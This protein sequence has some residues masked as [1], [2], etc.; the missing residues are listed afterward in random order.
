MDDK[1]DS[2]HVQVIKYV[3]QLVLR[4]NGGVYSLVSTGG[5]IGEAYSI[6]GWALYP[7]GFSLLTR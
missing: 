3:R 2:Y 7:T 4:A 1:L 6:V 5:K